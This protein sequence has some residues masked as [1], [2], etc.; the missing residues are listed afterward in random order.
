FFRSPTQVLTL[1]GC[2]NS[3][4]RGAPGWL[5]KGGPIVDDTHFAC[6][7]WIRLGA[8]VALATTCAAGPLAAVAKSANVKT[9]LLNGCA[10]GPS[11][12]RIA[13]STPPSTPLPLR[14]VMISIGGGHG[15]TVSTAAYIT[16]VWTWPTSRT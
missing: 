6:G 9:A 7:S 11:R 10:G 15:F 4:L 3:A 13:L 12:Q 1:N 16:P 2:A 5:V 8:H 14:S